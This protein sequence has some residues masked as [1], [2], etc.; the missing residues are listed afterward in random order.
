MTKK[1]ISVGE[2]APDFKLPNQDGE[3]IS[4][5]HFKGKWLILYFYPRDN[6]PGCIIEGIEFS[7]VLRDFEEM[8]AIV[9]GVSADSVDSHCSFISKQKLK[10]ALLS[11]PDKEMI[12]AYG[13]WQKKKFMGRE[14]MGIVRSTFLVDPDGKLA[15]I[16]PKVSSKG[17]AAEVKEKLA[18]LLNK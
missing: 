17:H 1:S 7:S 16:W 2:K 12:N 3:I 9:V 5:S 11:D 6:T 15:F 13:V 14:F 10:I 18:E 4:L 8:N